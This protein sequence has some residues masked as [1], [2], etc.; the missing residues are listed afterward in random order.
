MTLP[1][2][3]NADEVIARHFVHDNEMRPGKRLPD[4]S[5]FMPNRNLRTS[6]YRSSGLEEAAIRE[7]GE[8]HVA[9]M[10]G[11]LKGHCCKAAQDF[12]DE[13][14]SFDADGHPHGRHANVV[15]WTDDQAANRIKAK[16]LADKAMAFAVYR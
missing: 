4:Y 1:T 8:T 2:Q 13:G 12:L 10:R 3:V 9:P 14:L 7:I 5:S 15:G 11:P 6:V 16:K